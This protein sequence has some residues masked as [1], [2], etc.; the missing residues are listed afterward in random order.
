MIKAIIFDFDGL[1]LDTEG[2]WYEA[3]K[4]TL[5]EYGF[6][7]PL[8]EFAKC[9]GTDDT[10]FYKYLS[11]KIGSKINRDDIEQKAASKH[12]DMM[13]SPVAREG[14]KSYLDEA[15]ELGLKIGL[16]SSSS[17]Q[18]VRGFL[19]ELALLEYFDVLKTKEDVAKVKPDPAL[20]Q[21]AVHAL[22]IDPKETIAFEDSLNG[23]LAAKAAGLYCAIVP[24]EVTKQLAFQTHDLHLHSMADLSLVEVIEHIQ[25]I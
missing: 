14:V 21:E 18:W 16:A 19:K 13:K 20:Y 5:A 22:G 9:I 6:D 11:R 24:N 4:E 8:E 23:L 7:L 1:I 25:N 2:F 12:T 3:Y 15:R 10:V 17:R